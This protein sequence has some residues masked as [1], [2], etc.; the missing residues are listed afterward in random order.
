MSDVVVREPDRDEVIRQVPVFT[1]LYR[2]TYAE[3]PY[4]EGERHVTAFVE[5]FAT[6]AVS[7][8]FALVVAEIGDRTVGFAHGVTFDADTWWD[9]ADCEPPEVHGV[10]TFA[11]MEF[12]VGRAERGRGIGSALM[13]RLLG[14]RTEPYATLCANPAAPARQIYQRWGWKPVAVAHPAAIGIMDVLLLTLPTST[15]RA[16]VT[17]QRTG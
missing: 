9:E 10:S 3:P 5:R 17:G 7:P 13:N 1:N 2:A 11:V 6:E 16:S 8:G 15:N 4:R 12:I 14:Q